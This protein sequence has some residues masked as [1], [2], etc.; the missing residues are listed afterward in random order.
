MLASVLS[1]CMFNEFV[2]GINKRRRKSQ[3]IEK[4]ALKMLGARK[5]AKELSERHPLHTARGLAG[6]S[7]GTWSFSPRGRGHRGGGYQAAQARP[8]NRASWPAVQGGDQVLLKGV[9]WSLWRGLAKAG[10]GAGSFQAAAPHTRADPDPDQSTDHCPLSRCPR[11][12]SARPYTLHSSP[13]S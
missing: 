2:E 10:H 9:R 11:Q 6:S 12:R 1:L 3:L 5:H 4:F 13:H 8:T 7:P